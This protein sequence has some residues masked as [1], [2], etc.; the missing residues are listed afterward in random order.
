MKVIHFCTGC[1][2]VRLHTLNS[3]DH[4]T[5]LYFKMFYFNTSVLI[6]TDNKISWWVKK[7]LLKHS[8]H[9]NIY[10]KG[11][12]HSGLALYENEEHKECSVMPQILKFERNTGKIK[13]THLYKNR[14]PRHRQSEHWGWELQLGLKN[15]GE[16]TLKK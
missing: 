1:L 5:V 3:P 6:L 15:E 11:I 13:L 2:S 4:F 14:L 10:S 16:R 12:I 9:K 7:F 8:S